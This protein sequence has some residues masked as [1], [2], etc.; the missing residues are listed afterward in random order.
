MQTSLPQQPDLFSNHVARSRLEE[1]A[2]GYEVRVR[3]DARHPVERP[4]NAS[5]VWES[6]SSCPVGVTVPSKC[7]LDTTLDHPGR[8]HD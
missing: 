2:S 1:W 4:T 3:Q 5:R 7:Q 8:E 6:E